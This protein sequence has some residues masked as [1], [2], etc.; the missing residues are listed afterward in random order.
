MRL[1]P[2]T[3]DT[4]AAMAASGGSVVDAAPGFTTDDHTM[5][6]LSKEQPATLL[7]EPPTVIIEWPDFPSDAKECR[8]KFE[9]PRWA[10]HTSFVSGSTHTPVGVELLGHGPAAFPDPDGLDGTL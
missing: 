3:G 4:P 5:P 2:P 7:D 9:L 8:S 10:I 1:L 6:S